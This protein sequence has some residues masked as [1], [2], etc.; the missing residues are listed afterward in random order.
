MSA[1]LLPIREITAKLNI[2]DVFVEPWGTH[3]AKLR[4]ELLS[5]SGSGLGLAIVEQVVKMH[6][7]SIGVQ[8]E[9]GRGSV[10]TIELPIQP[11]S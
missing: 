11:L 1:P 6:G 10:F 2:P 8:S 7:G 9:P 5:A 3:I 4:L